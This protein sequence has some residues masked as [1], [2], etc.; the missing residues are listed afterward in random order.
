MERVK[1]LGAVITQ[2]TSTAYALIALESNDYDLVITD[3]SRRKENGMEPL[4]G[5]MLAR[6]VFRRWPAIPVYVYTKAA[7]AYATGAFPH[8][9]RGTRISMITSS[10]EGLLKKVFALRSWIRNR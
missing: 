3:I 6:K 8:E 9:A 1:S 4:A 10:K 5:F 7:E 2:T